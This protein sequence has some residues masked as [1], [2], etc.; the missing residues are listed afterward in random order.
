MKYCQLLAS[1]SGRL[2]A[3]KRLN[4]FAVD[5]PLDTGLRAER[6][7]VVQAARPRPG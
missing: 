3:M 6:L 4:R 2:A 5:I 1:R 7:A